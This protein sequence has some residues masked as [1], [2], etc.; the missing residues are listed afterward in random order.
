[1]ISLDFLLSQYNR[2]AI[3]G[4]RDGNQQEPVNLE[5]RRVRIHLPL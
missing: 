4:W 5:L 3:G 2:I 1:M